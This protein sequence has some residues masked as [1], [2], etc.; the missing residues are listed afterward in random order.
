MK[1]VQ[2]RVEPHN[3]FVAA[4][5]PPNSVKKKSSAVLYS[6]RIYLVYVG[7][8]EW[9]WGHQTKKR[10]MQTYMTLFNVTNSSQQLWGFLLESVVQIM[11]MTLNTV[12]CNLWEFLLKVNQFQSISSPLATVVKKPQKKWLLT[13]VEYHIFIMTIFCCFIH[14]VQIFQ[15]ISD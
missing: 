6:T 8:T 11:M 2:P 14:T 7:W 15:V 12:Q 1:F 5:R 13:H 3:K 4:F 9:R 10:M